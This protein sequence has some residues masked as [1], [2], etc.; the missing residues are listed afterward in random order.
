MLAIRSVIAIVLFCGSLANAA[1]WPCWHL[2]LE[3]QD[4]VRIATDHLEGERVAL[5]RARG[6][7]AG[8]ASVEGSGALPGKALSLARFE[9]VKAELAI[10]VAEKDL[11]VA[12]LEEEIWRRRSDGAS[13]ESVKPVY[14][15]LWNARADALE[16][17]AKVEEAQLDYETKEH[18]R[19][20]GLATSQ[21][22]PPRDA[23]DALFRLQDTTGRLALLR[24]R[25]EAARQAA[26]GLANS[27]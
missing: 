4:R 9:V 24:A 3:A 17:E 26:K 2:L 18:A 14:A 7:L 11:R 10:G 27:H 20:S 21:A 19:L 13:E 22:I 25:A 23:R 12:M 16:A 8:Y 15:D 6:I 5:E 1:D